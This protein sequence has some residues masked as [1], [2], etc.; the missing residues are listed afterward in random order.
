MI[1]SL[2]IKKSTISSVFHSSAEKIGAKGLFER[3]ASHHDPD[4]SKRSWLY[5]KLLAALQYLRERPSLNV[6]VVIP[7]TFAILYYGLFASNVYVTEATFVLH[8][9]T[10]SAPAS[11]IGSFLKS[12]G[13]SSLGKADENLAA[14]AEFI[15]SR[16]AMREIDDK[17][18]LRKEWS[19]WWIDPLQR[20][21]PLSLGKRY[22]NLYPYYKKHVTTDMEKDSNMCTLTV[23]GYTAEQSLQIN[24]FLLQAAEQ[25]VNRLNERA[26]QNMI[27][28]ATKEVELAQKMVKD[29]SDKMTTEAAKVAFEGGPLAVKDAQYQ[30]LLLD[31]EFAKEQL[32]SAMSSLQSARNQAIRQDLYLEVVSKPNLPDVAMEPERFHNIL[33]VL[34]V[35]LLLWGGWTLFI[36][37]VKEHQY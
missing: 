28:Y 30:Q 12:S 4:G 9:V 2:K 31:R 18:N 27:G 14:V 25:L 3:I 16:D 37:G 5:T 26:R 34:A 19:R 21:A 36:A 6:I 13:I 15:T 11:G 7:T 10:Q 29:A 35:T 1:E 20:F 8:S 23:R 24:E 33:S 32:S 17:V 22:E